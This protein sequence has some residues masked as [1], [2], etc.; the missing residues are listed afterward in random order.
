MSIRGL[1]CNLSGGSRNLH[2][3]TYT[4]LSVWSLPSSSSLHRISICKT[5]TM[6]EF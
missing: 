3:V 1:Y 2:L 4:N 6:S 5:N